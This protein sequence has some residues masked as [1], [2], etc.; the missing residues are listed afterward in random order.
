MLNF[1]KN[2]SLLLA[3]GMTLAVSATT[4]AN[5]A[6]PATKAAKEHCY[7]VKWR[8]PLSRE[9]MDQLVV[10]DKVISWKQVVEI[11]KKRAGMSETYDIEDIPDD[12][13][14]AAIVSFEAYGFEKDVFYHKTQAAAKKP[15]QKTQK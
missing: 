15:V 7:S 10:S 4:T 14:E 5:A 12:E 1:L 9:W 3:L 11:M 13:C 8:E 6:K 2:S